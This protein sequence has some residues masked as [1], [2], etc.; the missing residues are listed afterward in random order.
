MKRRII[1][2]VS[3]VVM[4]ACVF[5]LAACG[6]HTV[7]LDYGYDNKTEKFSVGDGEAFTLPSPTR[8]GYTFDGWTSGGEAVSGKPTIT[9]DVT[10]TA[11]WTKASDVAQPVEVTF[12]VPS[13]STAPAA[14]SVLPGEEVTLPA[15]PQVSGKQF[16]GWT[17]DGKLYQA[18]EKVAV[19]AAMTF[20]ATYK[21]EVAVRYVVSMPHVTAPEAETKLG[22][23]MLTL[24]DAPQVEGYAFKGWTLNGDDKLYQAGEQVAVSGTVMTFEAEYR[25]VVTLSFVTRR[26]KTESFQAEVGADF[27]IPEG[28]Q[29]VD[30]LFKGWSSSDSDELV[31]GGAVIKVPDHDVTYS[32]VYVEAVDVTFYD[33]KGQIIAVQ[34]IEKGTDATIPDYTYPA[35]LE[36]QWWTTYMGLSSDGKALMEDT[37]IKPVY[38]IIPSDESF[39]CFEEDSDGNYLV[40]FAKYKEGMN[41]ADITE[42]ILPAEYQGKPVV[43]IYGTA[44]S[45]GTTAT[46]ANSKKGGFALSTKLERVFIP[47][48]YTSLCNNA[49]NFDVAL[50]EVA[51]GEGIALDKIP[52]GA[53]GYCS[54]LSTIIIPDSVT[55]I[56]KSAFC[57]SGL[58]QIVI[59]GNVANINEKAFNGCG[60]LS[61]VTFE[62][63]D[64]DLTF[65]N[66]AFGMLKPSK[67]VPYESALT[68]FTF[69]A[70]TVKIGQYVLQC[71]M[72]LKE[73]KFEA[74][75]GE[76]KALTIDQYAF[77]GNRQQ[78]K[79]T[80]QKGTE[81]AYPY[82]SELK[83]ISIPARTVSIGQEAFANQVFI[84]ELIFEE[85][86]SLKTLG[87]RVCFGMV[88][89]QSLSISNIKTISTAAFGVPTGTVGIDYHTKE[90]PVDTLTTEPNK[91]SLTKVIIGQGVDTI[92]A[93]AFYGQ[94]NIGELSLDDGITVINNTAFNIGT[95]TNTALTSLILPKSLTKFGTATASPFG[96]N[97]EGLTSILFDCPNLSTVGG[98]GSSYNGDVDLVITFK[99]IATKCTLGNSFNSTT[100]VKSIVFENCDQGEF[101]FNG[102]FKGGW[103]VRD[104]LE[105]GKN[106]IPSVLLPKNCTFNTETFEFAEN[107]TV[108]FDVGSKYSTDESGKIIYATNDDGSK[109]LVKYLWSN[110]EFDGEED[111]VGHVAIAGSVLDGV[112][113]IG[114][115][116]FYGIP[117]TSLTIPA[118][119]TSIGQEAFYGNKLTTL[120]IPSTVTTVGSKSF[121]SAKNLVSV[122]CDAK[123]VETNAFVGCDNLE[124]I[125]FGEHN[126]TLAWTSVD[127]PGNSTTKEFKLTEIIFQGSTAKKF[128]GG[129]SANL[130][131]GLTNGGHFKFLVD[132]ALVET[133]KTLGIPETA[134]ATETVTV[135]FG[136]GE[137]VTVIKGG[138]IPASKIPEGQWQNGEADFDPS[139][140]ITEDLVLT[141]KSA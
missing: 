116:A 130:T 16:A 136:D 113:I 34:T 134:I 70:R 131:T 71:C 78:T 25:A 102:C 129:T 77:A 95:L 124:S 50:K 52:V 97:W 38:E 120:E 4:L 44:T 13:G 48:S 67:T 10:F 121:N 79:L 30:H 47:A 140:A 72:S 132:S 122:V 117:A 49:F 11:S 73:L 104:G 15:A 109:T 45:L 88:S 137:P 51:F 118:T 84:E 82:S 57:N 2:A 133:Y 21:T 139:A 80:P 42:L 6:E 92:N 85:G 60:K 5:V 58:T 114:D 36:G 141:A 14:Q 74:P 56:D 26:I 105:R 28:S 19:Q 23:D 7:T 53:F 54:A 18:G 66:Y 41:D 138:W 75:K 32:S 62:E 81:S 128:E 110:V 103:S 98:L 125:T 119:V 112:A 107:L 22:G 68:S 91:A 94:H 31:L 9:D 135:T 39:F 43:G 106:T 33:E 111:V 55:T 12:T 40:A 20:D 123:M 115:R 64:V 35:Q 69:P 61:S 127:W 59:P 89:L 17:C 46:N 37:E 99:N 76:P 65:G 100:Q 108:S 90:S 126:T 96:G 27:T 29:F 8:D 83:S 87:D 86:M 63:S 101:V 3:V 93:N 24:P 1:I